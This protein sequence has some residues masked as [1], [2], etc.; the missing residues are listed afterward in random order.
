MKLRLDLEVNEHHL[1][2]LAH[3]YGDSGWASKDQMRTYLEELIG[4]RLGRL[5]DDL[6]KHEGENGL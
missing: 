6:I 1:K 4:N 3:F 2:A 5:V